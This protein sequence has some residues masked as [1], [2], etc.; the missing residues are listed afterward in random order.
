MTENDNLN[1]FKIIQGI[2]DYLITR[3]T[4]PI[5]ARNYLLLSDNS[6]LRCEM[7]LNRELKGIYKK[8]QVV[9]YRDKNLNFLTA[10]EIFYLSAIFNSSIVQRYFSATFMNTS[11]NFRHFSLFIPKYNSQHPECLSLSQAI[12]STTVLTDALRR[13]FSDLYIKLCKS[14]HNKQS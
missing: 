9:I 4:P 3:K 7:F 10:A 5:Y 8:H 14:I 2:C 11:F 13:E 1:D 12:N 6:K